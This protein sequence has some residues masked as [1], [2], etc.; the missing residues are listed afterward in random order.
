MPRSHAGNMGTCVQTQ[1]PENF[2]C[3]ITHL[4]SP[5]ISKLLNHLHQSC[6][7]PASTDL[8][9]EPGQVQWANSLITEE[10]KDSLRSFHSHIHWR[11][12]PHIQVG[13]SLLDGYISAVFR[14]PNMLLWLED[15]S[16]HRL[17]QPS[18]AHSGDTDTETDLGRAST[19][20]SCAWG[21]LLTLIMLVIHKC[22]KFGD[23]MINLSNKFTEM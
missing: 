14:W 10:Q 18:K 4:T 21:V 9:K 3:G 1:C 15:R 12:F 5:N 2:R 13:S 6:V 7:T 23:F 20:A 16:T 17:Q 11:H 8:E 22:K 19:Y